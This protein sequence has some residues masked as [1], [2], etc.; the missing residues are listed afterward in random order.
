MSKIKEK[1]HLLTIAYIKDTEKFLDSTI[2]WVGVCLFSWKSTIFGY[3]TLKSQ[4]AE[5][6]L[7][8]FLSWKNLQSYCNSKIDRSILLSKKIYFIN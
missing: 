8:V 5:C 4:N 6:A 3:A 7:S 2:S 1:R